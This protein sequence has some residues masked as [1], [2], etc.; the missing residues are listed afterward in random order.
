VGGGRGGGGGGGGGAGG[1]TKVRQ[2]IHAKHPNTTFAM[3]QRTMSEN[4][5]NNRPMLTSAPRP[6]QRPGNNSRFRADLDGNENEV[7]KPACPP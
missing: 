3:A 5:P 4:H 1:I 2:P 7:G 6:F